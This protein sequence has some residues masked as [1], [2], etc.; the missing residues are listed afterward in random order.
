MS[1]RQKRRKMANDEDAADRA[2]GG[3]DHNLAIRNAKKAARPVKITEALPKT[4]AQ[5]KSA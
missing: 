4:A 2:A 1:R 3:H 5:K